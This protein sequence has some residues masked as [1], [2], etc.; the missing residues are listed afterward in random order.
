MARS[1]AQAD[2]AEGHGLYDLVTFRA[3]QGG[4]RTGSSRRRRFRAQAPEVVLDEPPGLD[5]V[6]VASQSEGCVAGRIVG[7]EKRANVF[8]G[9]SA[10]ITARADDRAV[11]GMAGGKEGVEQQERARPVRRILVGLSSLVLDDAAL[12]GKPVPVESVQH[13]SHSVAFQPQDQRQL[14]ARHGRE[15]VGPVPA[16]G[17]V[18][19]GGAD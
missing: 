1:R 15:V 8:E 4:G 3:H 11:V 7:I 16:G 14:L 12:S 17:R 6:E 5:W 18:D 9:G 13:E 19:V 10:E 2:P